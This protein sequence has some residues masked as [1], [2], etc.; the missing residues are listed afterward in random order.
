[1]VH[2]KRRIKRQELFRQYDFYREEF[3][4]RQQIIGRQYVS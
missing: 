4:L 3:P 2:K 1:M